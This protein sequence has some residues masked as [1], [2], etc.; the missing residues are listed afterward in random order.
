M[1]ITPRF[2]TRSA[3]DYNASFRHCESVQCE[4]VF[5]LSGNHSTKE[6]TAMA[7]FT[8][9][10]REKAVWVSFTPAECARMHE[11]AQELLHDAPME[12]HMSTRRYEWIDYQSGS[13][14]KI[15]VRGWHDKEGNWHNHGEPE[16]PTCSLPLVIAECIKLMARL[17]KPMLSPYKGSEIH[18]IIG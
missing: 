18:W 12:H 13:V 6:V 16:C 5:T 15:T 14:Y 11:F 10:G 17:S 3:T 9:G 7:K 1:K 2:L 4:E 8:E